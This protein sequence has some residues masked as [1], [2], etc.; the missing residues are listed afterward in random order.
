[1]IAAAVLDVDP[2]VFSKRAAG[3]VLLEAGQ[4]LEV[5]GGTPKGAGFPPWCSKR[6]SNHI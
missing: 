2:T 1:M 5:A 6:P 3:D 4:L